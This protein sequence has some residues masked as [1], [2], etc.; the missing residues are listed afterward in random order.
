MKKFLSWTLLLALLLG[1]T[2]AA[3]AADGADARL[4]RVTAAV[5]AALGLDTA[6]YDSFRGV[7]DEQELVPVWTLYWTGSGGSLNVEALEDGTVIC[8][9]L[10]R[11]DA[12]AARPG[13]GGIPA[14]PA[15]SEAAART[16]AEAFLQ[17]V[18][19][20]G[21]SAEVGESRS[22][23]DLR[24]SGCYF[25]GD[26]LLNGVPSPLSWSLTVGA[27]GQ[28]E[29]FRRD[30]AENTWLGELPGA[31]PAVAQSAAAQSLRS[32]QKL[33][34]EYVRDGDTAVLRYLPEAA[35]QFY[36]D[37]QTGAL[38]DLTE[39]QEDMW[40]NAPTGGSDN[41]SSAPAAAEDAGEGGLSEAEQAG[42]AQ[43]AGVLSRED[44]DR[45]LRAAAEYGLSR[46]TLVSARYDQAADGEVRP[47]A[48]G[49]QDSAGEEARILCTLRYS[50]A[51]Q[52]GQVST[53]VFTVDAKTG[54]L[55]W[56]YSTAP[57]RENARAAVSPAQA[58]AKAEAFLQAY[59]PD[60]A[61]QLALYES[62]DRTGDGAPFYTFTFARKVN[63]YFFPGSAYT[64][65]I[66]AADGA[67]SSLHFDYD[68]ALTF[69][70]PAGI[71]SADAALDAWMETYE[72]RLAYLAV[73]QPLTGSGEAVQRLRQLGHKSFYVPKLGYG[74]V[75]ADDVPGIDAKTGQPVRVEE[76]ARTAAYTDVANHWA[77]AEIERLAQY[78]VG[79]E[80]DR[81]Q[82]RKSLTQLD[83][84][85]LLASLEGWRGDPDSAADQERD[86]AYSI[87]YELGALTRAERQDAAVLS[88]AAA[89]R[90]LLNAAGYSPAASLQGIY[91]C[92]YTDRQSI[93][94]SELGYA[95]IAQA[96]GLVGGAYA[97]TRAAT[98]A[99]AAVMLARLMDR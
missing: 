28:V 79:Y 53:R 5:K 58:Q 49:A 32:T 23:N 44:L 16:A 8:Y 81:F 86:T 36:V 99:E 74:L 55:A 68:E 6:A 12:Q 83:L 48:N 20:P 95:S 27:D 70:D 85:Y 76:P 56:F 73:P 7:C 67:V 66:D 98:R 17:K 46:Y 92:N 61:A 50:R 37:A 35:H 18:L 47:A 42:I 39:L 4:S 51:A 10:E 34:L 1:L 71:V 88:R 89:V 69:Q 30:V 57:W 15:G 29:R 75:R 31:A 64:V 77:K 25:S 41:A 62:T 24:G 52:G 84:V 93:P 11:E 91:T 22:G 9:R 65:G 63:G 97:G 43:M 2:P 3:G 80:S 26:L 21:E 40:K 72:V 19:A 78:G 82:P 13:F 33:R 38:V 90:M 94:A 59:Y 87:A 14:F 96:L 45:Q 54:A 60:H